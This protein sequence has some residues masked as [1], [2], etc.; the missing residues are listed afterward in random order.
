[1]IVF[2]DRFLASIE[3]L[4][5]CASLTLMLVVAS[6][7]VILRNGFH[8]G[9]EWA[10]VL[11][12][13]L[14]LFLLFFGASLATRDRRHIQMDISSKLVPAKLKPA[15]DLVIN[16]FCIFITILLFKAS[17]TF[18]ADEKASGDI[19]FLNIP[20]W[21]FVLVMPVGFALISLRF[22]LN[23]FHNVRALCGKEPYHGHVGHEIP[24][25]AKD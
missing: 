24:L 1:M 17:Y 11:V 4:C 16:L 20:N 18:T 8:S 5:L 12:R 14:V 13:H 2:I 6:L 7:Q 10:D 22:A 3:K 19:L 23:G 25:E 15:L 21:I 9:I